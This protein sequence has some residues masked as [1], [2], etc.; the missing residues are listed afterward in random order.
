MAQLEMDQEQS[1]GWMWAGC[2]QFWHSPSILP[3]TS[4]Y[5]LH[6]SCVTLGQSLCSAAA[7]VTS[8][9]KSRWLRK[10]MGHGKSRSEDRPG[11]QKAA[12]QRYLKVLY[13]VLTK[14]HPFLPQQRSLDLFPL[15]CPELR[16]NI[17]TS[18]KETAKCPCPLDKMKKLS[19]FVK[20][21]N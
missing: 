12:V 4:H 5:Y 7:L 19:S 13:N 10:G 2:W 16:R 1:S 8:L 20:V 14:V 9:A 6:S 15:L 21:F 18:T 3:R 11:T 17:F